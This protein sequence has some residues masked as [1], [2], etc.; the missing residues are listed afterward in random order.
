MF[1]GPANPRA[2]FCTD[3]GSPAP[4]VL[5]A[6]A[7]D[8]GADCRIKGNINAAGERI[9]HLPGQAHYSRTRIDEGRGQRWFC[10]E[11][12]ARAAGWRR[13]RR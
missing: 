2:G 11:A 8:E 6:S 3:P 9:Y 5:G 12:E 1:V 13:A 7:R 4:P 10:S